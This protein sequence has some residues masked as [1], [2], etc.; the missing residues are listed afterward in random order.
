MK[1]RCL[2]EPFRRLYGGRVFH[3]R[4]A[5]SEVY[6]RVL[7]S[8]GRQVLEIDAGGVPVQLQ[9][10]FA[11][12]VVEATPGGVGEPTGSRVRVARHPRVSRRVSAAFGP[13][14]EPLRELGTS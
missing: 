5:E 6:K 9:P 4:L 1:V 12:E 10:P 14:K 2:S 13:R 11:L 8:M 7:P 3:A